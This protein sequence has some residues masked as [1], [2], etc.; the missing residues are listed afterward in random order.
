[1]SL[2]AEWELEQWDMFPGKVGNVCKAKL[3]LKTLRRKGL[4]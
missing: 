3:I 1:M 2:Q 4:G